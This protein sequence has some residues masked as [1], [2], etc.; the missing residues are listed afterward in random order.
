MS[1]S[2]GSKFDWGMRV[3]ATIDLFND[4]SYPEHEAEALLVKA[5]DPG[6]IVQVGRHVESETTI[7][8]VEFGDKLVVGC[9]EEEI[10]PA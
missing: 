2:S 10:E 6:E 8:L 9:L 1:E 3:R 7:Y 5:G 4:G